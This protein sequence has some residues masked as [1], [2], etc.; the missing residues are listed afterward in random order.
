[1]DLIRI[2]DQ[3]R[4]GVFFCLEEKLMHQKGKT[5]AYKEDTPLQGPKRQIPWRLFLQICKVRRGR[6]VSHAFITYMARMEKRG[7]AALVP[8]RWRF[9]MRSCS[10]RLCSLECVWIASSVMVKL[11]DGDQRVLYKARL[12]VK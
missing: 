9:F 8:R 6:L 4:R 11:V 5:F 12:N 3:Q 10:V 7:K 1:M 2:V